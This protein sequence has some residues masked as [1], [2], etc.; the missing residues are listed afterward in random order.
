MPLNGDEKNLVMQDKTIIDN[1]SG[2][3][4]PG[5][6]TAIMGE[7]GAGKTSLL[8]ILSFR[9]K[10]DKVCNIKGDIRLNNS[11]YNLE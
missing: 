1:I 9:T 4:K 3:A 10:N 2:Y 5:G 7:S 11:E 6:I 8:N